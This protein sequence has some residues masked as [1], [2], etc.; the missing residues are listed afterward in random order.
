[1]YQLEIVWDGG[2]TA[3][4]ATVGFHP[5]NLWPSVYMASNAKKKCKLIKKH[6]GRGNFVLFLN[7]F[8]RFR[9]H[10]VVSKL[11][12]DSCQKVHA[13]LYMKCFILILFPFSF[14]WVQ[15]KPEIFSQNFRYQWFPII[16]RHGTE[17]VLITK[18]EILG[19]VTIFFIELACLVLVL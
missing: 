15:I 17:K 6:L 7:L 5:S 18:F 2:R 3:K 13:R 11:K 19:L 4:A 14:I 8:H 9:E 12:Q 10:P 1:M 16:T